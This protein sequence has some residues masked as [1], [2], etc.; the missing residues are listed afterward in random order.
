MKMAKTLDE[1]L[2]STTYKRKEIAL[3]LS[4][5]RPLGL[6]E[7]LKWGTPCFTFNKKIIIGIGAFKSYIGLWFC[8][9]VF[10]KD[11]SKV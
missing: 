6:Q 1:F 8:Q 11:D 7:T 2:E 9:G 5:L 4:I 3:L 10:L